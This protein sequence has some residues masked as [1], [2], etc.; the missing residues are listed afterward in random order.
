MNIL[1][2]LFPVKCP[3]C[4]RVLR[5]SEKGI[6]ADCGKRMP[7]VGEPC[8]KHCGKPVVSAETEY[9]YDC[10]GKVS[11]L[12]QGTAL[13]VYTEEMRKAMA[14]FKYGG[15]LSDGEFYV[16]ELLARKWNR[17]Q[18][19]NIDKIVPVPLHRRRKWFRGYNQA[20]CIAEGIG[21]AMKIPVLPEAL[22][23]TRY[24]RPQKGL[25]DRQRRENLR[26]AFTLNMKYESEIHGCSSVLLVDDIYTTGATLEACG[27]VLKEK[28]VVNVYFVCLCTGSDY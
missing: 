5:K 27:D 12:R 26:G 23:R 20:A 22:M 2:V 10:M 13:W 3:I 7:F 11:S 1:D 24:T 19:W 15:C 25:D 16:S 14:D 18:S 9:C 28:G 8:C 4:G 21:R 6:C 17:L